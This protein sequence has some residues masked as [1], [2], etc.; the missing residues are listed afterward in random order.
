MPAHTKGAH[1]VAQTSVCGF[2]SKLGNCV[3]IRHR[4]KVDGRRL[5]LWFSLGTPQTEVCATKRKG[6][7][8]SSAFYLFSIHSL[9][10]AALR[11]RGANGFYLGVLLEDFVAHLAAPA[12]LF[13]SAEG[14]A[15]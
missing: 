12:G 8:K 6:R 5:Q 1:F 3:K 7:R 9:L 10:A 2:P 15:G 13:V 14:K 11:N 4:A